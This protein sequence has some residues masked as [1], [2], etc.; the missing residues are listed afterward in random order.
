V[1]I[2]K[3]QNSFQALEWTKKRRKDGKKRS[4]NGEVQMAIMSQIQGGK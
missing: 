4:E 1:K 2:F 3:R